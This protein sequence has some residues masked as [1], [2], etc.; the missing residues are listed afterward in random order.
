M[1]RCLDDL[2]LAGSGRPGTVLKQGRHD[3]VEVGDLFRL[4]EAND[5]RGP[6]RM[7]LPLSHEVAAFLGRE[8]LG[9]RA[10][11]VPHVAGEA[12]AA[13]PRRR[14]LEPIHQPSLQVEVPTLI[15]VPQCERVVQ[16]LA[17]GGACSTSGRIL[18]AAP[19]T[20]STT[21]MRAVSASIAV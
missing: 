21:R 17:V 1:N 6:R 14:S 11:D 7:R 4:A 15:E 8:F 20:F 19:S 10:D 12:V 3:L 13:F 16:L 18:A 2:L 5:G 9:D